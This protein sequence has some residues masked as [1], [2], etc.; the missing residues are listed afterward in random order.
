M[1]LGRFEALVAETVTRR[2]E[3]GEKGST[4]R[5]SPGRGKTKRRI[6]L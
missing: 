5:I 6:G 3:L 1:T 2:K 4:T